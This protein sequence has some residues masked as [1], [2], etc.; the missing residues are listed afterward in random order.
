MLTWSCKDS[1]FGKPVHDVHRIRHTGIVVSDLARA[2]PFYR[3]LLRLEIWAD[4]ED[5]SEYLATVTGVRDA[6]VRM[7]KLRAADG[8][9]VELLQYLSHPR[10]LHAPRAACELGCQHVAFEVR[11]LDE[12][13]RR[14]VS[15]GV[16]FHTPPAVSP[17]G[18]AKVTYCR[19]FEGVIVEL[20]EL[21][22]AGTSPSASKGA[23]Q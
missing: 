8:V 17:D 19:D 21:L 15:A 11:D 2:L 22:N 4:F 23:S 18:Y 16:Q 13:Y 12:L 20:V 7:V 14:M 5:A 9:S 3:D 1:I 6:R 10:K